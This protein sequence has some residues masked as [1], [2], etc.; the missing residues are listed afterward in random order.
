LAADRV[1]TA[2]IKGTADQESVVD[3]HGEAAA[4]HATAWARLCHMPRCEHDRLGGR[5]TQTHYNIAPTYTVDVVRPADGGATE[6][7]PMLSKLPP[8][9]E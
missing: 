7:V 4:V 3:R 1:T 2:A 6:L 8:K 9:D 5:F